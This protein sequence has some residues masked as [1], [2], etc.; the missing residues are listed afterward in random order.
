[1]EEYLKEIIELV[2]LKNEKLIIV[3]GEV[4][5]VR[6][7]DCDVSRDGQPDLLE[8]RFHAVLD[9]VNNFTKIKPKVG[10]VVLVG[11]IENSPVDA[12]IISYSEVDQVCVK[13]DS[14]LVEVSKIGI[15]AERNGQNLK[16]VLTDFMTAVN[17]IMVPTVAGLTPIDP[18][19]KLKIEA[20]I[21]QISQ[22]LI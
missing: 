20:A 16:T 15:R 1:M 2:L 19:S 11:L 22:I 9:T 8:V 7:L 6:D 18:Q 3:Q 13:I 12:F 17:G 14:T 10:S 21:S 4:K 5:A